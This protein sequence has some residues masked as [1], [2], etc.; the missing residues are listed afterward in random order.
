MLIKNA[1]LGEYYLGNMTNTI[2]IYMG[3]DRYGRI[4]LKSNEMNHYIYC[5]DFANGGTSGFSKMCYIDGRVNF[6]KKC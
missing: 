6:A 1:S 5:N 2:Y 4:V 3:K